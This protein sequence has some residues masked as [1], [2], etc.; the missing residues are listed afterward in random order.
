MRA[1]MLMRMILLVVICFVLTGTDAQ[2]LTIEKPLTN[3]DI[4]SM[5][6]AGINA[7]IIK[8]AIER[9]NTSFD[10]SPTAMIDLKK[11]RTPDDIV[12]A[13]L[14]KAGMK[15]AAA[16][17]DTLAMMAPGLYYG[18]GRGYRPVESHPMLSVISKGAA[19]KLKKVIGSLLNQ[20]CNTEIA[21][22]HATVII[23]DRKPIFVFILDFPAR[24]PEEFFLTRLLQTQDRRQ[25]SFRKI[26]NAPGI[27]NVSDTL[28][29]RFNFKKIQEG[30]YEV[31]PTHPLP[32]GEYGFIYNAAERYKGSVFNVF[33]FSI[34]S[35]STDHHE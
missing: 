21:G 6:G 2:V 32:N 26:S 35:P 10:L 24:N 33:D 22:V 11:C 30:V 3:K 19:G 17:K 12:L 13:M 8:A 20:T 4:V 31:A 27:I 15:A 18:L 34:L 28:K 14:S 16:P 9:S 25:F 29:I 7:G 1:K 5:V 23:E